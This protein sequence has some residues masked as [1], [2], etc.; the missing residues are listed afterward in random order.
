LRAAI[1]GLVVCTN[2][3]TAGEKLSAVPLYELD[4]IDLFMYSHI[5]APD[6]EQRLHLASRST[7][8]TRRLQVAGVTSRE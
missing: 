6:A 7:T 2:W 5:F 3:E 1:E 8:S 4:N